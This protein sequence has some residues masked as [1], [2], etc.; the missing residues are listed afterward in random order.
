MALNNLLECVS[1]TGNDNLRDIINQEFRNRVQAIINKPGFK[2]EMGSYES[3]KKLVCPGYKKD[4]SYYSATSWL[5]NTLLKDDY[6]FKKGLC[7]LGFVGTNLLSS[8]YYSTTSFNKLSSLIEF[9]EDCGKTILTGDII[10]YIDWIVN[11]VKKEHVGKHQSTRIPAQNR[12]RWIKRVEETSTKKGRV[13]ITF[14]YDYQVKQMKCDCKKKFTYDSKNR[15]SVIKAAESIDDWVNIE[16]YL[17]SIEMEKY[18]KGSGS[19]KDCIYFNYFYISADERD[20][21]RYRRDFSFDDDYIA[22]KNYLLGLKPGA[23]IT[24][25]DLDTIQ[26]LINRIERIV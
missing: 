26:S 18:W 5:Q 19:F 20:K 1:A 22:Y 6:N 11:F 13:T 21:E 8:C 25:T 16:G 9:Y 12:R 10:S 3:F 2:G 7:L 17:N 23:T 15:D 4:R 14:T 24:Q